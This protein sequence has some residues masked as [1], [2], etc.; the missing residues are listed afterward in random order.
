MRTVL[1]ALVL[2]VASATPGFGQ[3][4]IQCERYRVQ[5]GQKQDWTIF[6]LTIS[7]EKSIVSYKKVSGPDWFMTPK[8][9][10]QILWKSRDNLRVVA[11]WLN[12]KYGKDERVWHPVYIIDIDFS[13]PRFKM[14][15][16]GGFSDFDQLISSPW[17][18][19]C[20]RTD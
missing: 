8:A 9:S 18:Y 1:I 11:Y 17:E 6:T 3:K 2:L 19:E 13:K 15:T 12:E 7:P 16:Y 4:T 5:K 14:E 20:K 10:L